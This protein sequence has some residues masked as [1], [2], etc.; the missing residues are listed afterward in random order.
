MLGQLY[1]RILFWNSADQIGP[2][3]PTT[4]WKLYFKPKMIRLCKKKFFYFDD[5]AKIRPG[6]YIIGCSQISIGKNEVIR[7]LTQLHGETNTL[8]ISIVIEDDVLIGSGVH[9]Y[10]G[11]HNFSKTDEPIYYQGHS[12]SKKVTI[13]K[14]A[15]IGANAIILL[16]VEIGENSI[17][18][19]GSFVTKSI[20]KRCI[21]A[22]NP[23]RVMKMIEQ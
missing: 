10:I 4:H 14:G 7:P 20:P 23:A 6:A 8:D 1:R 3:V 11:N 13:R 15:W 22:G 21:A 12:P 9:V 5:T 16:G 18:G 17:I 2:D 19:A